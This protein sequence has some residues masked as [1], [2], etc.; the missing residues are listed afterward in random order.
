MVCILIVTTKNILISSNPSTLLISLNARDMVSEELELRHPM[1]P[2]H[3]LSTSMGTMSNH[4]GSNQVLLS[5]NLKCFARRL[6][7]FTHV[8]GSYFPV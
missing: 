8:L 1:V 7:D 3:D 6:I 5:L 2:T 4:V